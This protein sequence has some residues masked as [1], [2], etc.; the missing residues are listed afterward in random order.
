MGGS[1]MGLSTQMT[2]AAK[3]FQR[4]RKEGEMLA[5][6]FKCV[7]DGITAV[8]NAGGNFSEIAKGVT[9]SALGMTNS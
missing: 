6:G 2:D 4:A 5:R 1:I 3:Q 7:V 8:G 9:Q